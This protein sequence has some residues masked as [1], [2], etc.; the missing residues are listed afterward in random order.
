MNFLSWNCRGLGNPRAV[1]CLGDVLRTQKYDIVFLIETLSLDVRINELCRKFGYVFHFTVDSVCR[2]GDLALM[3]KFNVL[4]DVV[5]HFSNFID[6]HIFKQGVADLRLTGFYG[7]PD[8]SRRRESWSLIRSPSSLSSLPW[9]IVGD[10]ND[11]L[12]ESDKKGLVA[13]PQSLLDGFKNIISDSALTE[14]DLNGGSYTWE[15]SKGKSNWVREK[16]DRAFGCNEWWKK[17]P[18]CKLSLLQTVVSNHNHIFLD[19][20]STEFSMAK[21]RF[22]FENTWL[23]E[24]LFHDEVVNF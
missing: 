16:L 11:L 24:Q 1:R 22:K 10:F 2:S 18:S 12:S 6:A 9:C 3:R 13:H 15:K 20:V 23:K 5:V 19:L 21:F 7:Y 17:F 14:V 4:C 8:R